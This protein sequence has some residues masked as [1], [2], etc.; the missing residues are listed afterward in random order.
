MSS[1]DSGSQGR[2][3]EGLES[4]EGKLDRGLPRPSKYPQLESYGSYL[5]LGI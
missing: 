4:R 5:V 2:H 1:G 3:L